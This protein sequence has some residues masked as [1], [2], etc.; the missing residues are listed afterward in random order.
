MPVPRASAWFSSINASYRYSGLVHQPQEMPNFVRELLHEIV[1]RTE[2]DFNSILVNLYQD[3]T[4]SMG[5]HADDE[6][7]LGPEVT[8]ASLSVGAERELRFRHRN[9]KSL[10]VA[11]SL[12]HGSL[13]MMYPPLQEYWMHELPKRPSITEPRIN[14]SFRTLQ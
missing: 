7:E 5:W 4:Q 9:D 3:G 2:I 10:R 6:A 1:K 14:F 12:A 13:L 8:I 11:T